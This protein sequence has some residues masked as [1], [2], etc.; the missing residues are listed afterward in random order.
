MTVHLSKEKHR[1]NK[2]ETN[3][4]VYPETVDRRDGEMSRSISIVMTMLS[5]ALENKQKSWCIKQN[6]IKKTNEPN[7]LL[8]QYHNEIKEENNVSTLVILKHRILSIYSHNNTNNKNWKQ[9]LKL[10]LVRL[11]VAGLQNSELLPMYSK[12]Q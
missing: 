12:I 8:N 7:Y 4:M 5:C 6:R 1:E 11:R 3:E 10:Q 9:T 2:S